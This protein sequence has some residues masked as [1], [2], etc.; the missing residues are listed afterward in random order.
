MDPAWLL[1][2][3]SNQPTDACVRAAL[4]ALAAQ[5]RATLL[6]P[7]RRFPSDS[8][9][10][11]QYYNALLE[12]SPLDAAA[13]MPALAR[14]L[15]QELGR[16]RGHPDEVVIDIDVLAT[17]VDGQWRA[18]PHA[19][20]KREFVRPSVSALLREAAV[21]VLMSTRSET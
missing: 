10:R 17:R 3:G 21:E 19:M 13:P 18:H 2:L 9:D 7:I 14:R 16:D 4:A 8:G 1:L 11:S 15:E 5:G 12:W 6:A 20:Q